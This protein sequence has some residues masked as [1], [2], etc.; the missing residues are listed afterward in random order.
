V[1][2]PTVAVVVLLLQE[3]WDSQLMAERVEQMAVQESSMFVMHLVRKQQQKS[4]LWSQH[5]RAR[6]ALLDIE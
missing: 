1:G 3:E 6:V 4:T 2:Q 5:L